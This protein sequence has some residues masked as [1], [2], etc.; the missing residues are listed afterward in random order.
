MVAFEGFKNRVFP[1]KVNRSVEK[2]KLSSRNGSAK[3]ELKKA[4]RSINQSEASTRKQSA[5]IKK[6]VKA[7]FLN[8]L[9]PQSARGNRTTMELVKPKL[10]KKI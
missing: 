4:S 3:R 2:I 5:H 8:R 1:Y 10:L 6:A 9:F 7:Q